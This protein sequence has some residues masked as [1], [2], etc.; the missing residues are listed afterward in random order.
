MLPI[1]IIDLGGSTESEERLQ[2]L[3]ASTGMSLKPFWRYYHVDKEPIDDVAS[4]MSM[5]DE[6]IAEGRDCYNS[7]NKTGYNI[8]NF[9]IVI[10]GAANEELTQ[11]IF[12]PLPGLLRDNLPKIIPDH[13]NLGVEI[14]GIL[15]IPSTINQ[16]DDE[17]ARTRA[18]MLLEDVN[19]L[20]EHLGSRHFNRVVAYQDIQYKGVRFYS[21]LNSQQQAELLFQILAHLFFVS[22]DCERLF[23]KIG[24]ES[25][26]FSLGAASIFYDSD[27]HH[28]YVLKQLLDKLLAA[29]KD[30][31][32]TD[33]E[34]A[35][36]ILPE[37]LEEDVI[38][39]ETITRRLLERCD[40]LDV[41]LMKMDEE[42]VPHPV[43]NLFCANL[44]PKY[45]FKFLKYMPA[46][47]IKFMQTISYILL[48]RFS[49][50]IR[51]N[52]ETAA[53]NLKEM[54]SSI[55]KKV[56]L[57][58]AAKF[59]TIAQI[60]SVFNTAKEY[61]LNKQTEVNYALLEIVPIP[62]YL[63]HDYDACL[64]DEDDNNPSK[65][66]EKL[67]KN[68]KKEPVVLS[69]LIR[70]FLLGILLV[71]TV[72]PV[73]RVVSPTVINLGEAATIEWLW[74]PILFLLP[75]IIE[76][77]IKLRRHFKRIRRLKYRLLATT[78]LSLNKRLSKLLMDELIALY[79]SL[80]H[81]CDLHLELLK[82]F[83]HSL[84]VENTESVRSIIPETMFN[85]PLIGGS[86][87][88]EKLLE[89]ESVT[90]GEIRIKDEN[91]HLSRLE[92]EDLLYLLKTS[93]RKTE[94]LEAA[95]LS[96]KQ[97]V[98][99]HASAFIPMLKAFFGPRL[100]INTADDI[101]LMLT[102][103]DRKVNI[104]PLLKMA[105]V[106]GM[107]FS[108]TA[109]NKPILK[110]TNA[111]RLFEDVKLISDKATADY[112]FY[113]NWQKLTYGIQSQHVCNCQLDHLPE[114]TISDKLSL[115]YGF[116]RQKD[117]AYTLAGVPIRI[118]KTDMDQLNKEI[119]G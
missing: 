101:G 51:Q 80:I 31:E 6:L 62:K 116:Y 74:I 68:L 24:I 33:P 43:W 28:S 97:S 78:L 63:R 50:I 64:N 76:F 48:T 77:L 59:S 27:Q 61:L 82:K 13:A 111:P 14:T 30:T 107:L 110:I 58:P 79:E 42:P 112:A 67:K 73:L 4:C 55:Y 2:T 49:G 117:L 114:L 119:G 113:T 1:W 20:N 92:N 10:I 47:I 44:F 95:D 88:G 108:V 93:F 105:G 65:I 37:V 104:A 7:F 83:R 22:T 71:F 32:N 118:P 66:I 96:D 16:L 100:Q 94:T 86:F 26:T 25:G 46:R 53:V 35:E 89:D 91:V 38:N 98:K 40:S 45:Y 12:A 85:Q 52:K 11:S 9:Q 57:D 75:L 87:C 3:L 106:N 8:S 18:A 84:S 29:F 99:D 72:I 5:M 17:D 56:Y 54:L 70:C 90:E 41:N 102:L 19:M 39:P 69:L 15:Y 21:S 34:Y 115:L 36:K 23:D 81:E 109:K 103:L 60:E